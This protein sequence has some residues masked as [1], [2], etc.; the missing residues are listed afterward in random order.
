[1][2]HVFPDLRIKSE[3]DYQPPG[4]NNSPPPAPSLPNAN[5][6]DKPMETSPVPPKLSPD[7]WPAKPITSKS[8]GIATADGENV[9][10]VRVGNFIY[11]FKAQFPFKITLYCL[12]SFCL[13]E[14]QF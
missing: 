10:V 6:H 13:T 2:I 14:V 9:Q 4:Y 7:I 12:L 5:Y 3:N 11:L 8:G 1:M